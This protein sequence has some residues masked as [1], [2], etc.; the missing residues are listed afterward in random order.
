MAKHF[1]KTKY[2][3][4]TATELQIPHLGRIPQIYGR[5]KQVCEHS[6]LLIWDQ[7]KKD[8]EYLQLL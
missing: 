5:V 3:P 4:K 2:K 7:D 6:T 1:M 8:T